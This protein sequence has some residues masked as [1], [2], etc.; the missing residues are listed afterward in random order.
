MYPLVVVV[1]AVEVMVL[2]AGIVGVA[3]VVVVASEVESVAV[4]VEAEAY[5]D[6]AQDTEEACPV[7][8][9]L[10]EVFAENVV[11]HL[12]TMKEIDQEEDL[13]V[14]TWS[15]ICRSKSQV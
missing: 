2:T 13:S 12:D 9:A 5:Q 8:R 14:V 11:G 3:V 1:A 6:Y 10:G 7:A 4:G 15:A